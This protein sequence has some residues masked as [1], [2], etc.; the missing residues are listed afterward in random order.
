MND[1]R[2]L[3]NE[4]GQALGTAFFSAA[5][6]ATNLRQ[7]LA[8]LLQQLIQIAQSRAIQQIGNLFGNAAANF[9]RTGTQQG[10]SPN[11]PSTGGVRDE[12]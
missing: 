6:G 10:Q 7:A 5:T 4:V 1:L 12:G 3:G 8:Q 11:P 2:Q 9:G